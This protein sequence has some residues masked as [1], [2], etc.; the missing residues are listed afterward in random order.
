MKSSLFYLHNDAKILDLIR[1]GDDEESLATLYKA[2]R[3]PVVSYVM[4]NN[5]TADDAEDILQEAVVVLWEKVRSGQFHYESQLST[6]IM[7]IAKNIWLRRLARRRKEIPEGANIDEAIS[8]D[9]SPLE[10]LIDSDRSRLVS[11]SLN[12]LGDPCKKLLLLFYWEELP[13]EQIASVM[14]FAN[15]ETAKSKKYQCKKA[16]ERILKNE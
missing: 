3:R 5:G 6:F 14:G 4:K 11:D 13:L 12:K 8:L 15:A 16:L 7:G 9:P 2:N 10:E 1:K